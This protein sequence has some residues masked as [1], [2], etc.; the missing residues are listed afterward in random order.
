MNE[1]KLT[2]KQRDRLLSDIVNLREVKLPEA[3]E[4]LAA[5]AAN[6]DLS[7][8][9]DFD[10]AKEEIKN[11]HKDIENKE[12]LLNRSSLL[13]DEE[14]FS[15]EIR[16]GNRVKILVDGKVYEKTLTVSSGVDFLDNISPNSILGRELIGRDLMDKFM[17]KDTKGI[18]HQ[19]TILDVI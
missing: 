17:Y 15:P 7:E 2:K 11:I 6:G 13:A 9:S 18:E 1:I 19:V 16:T 10:S 4:R 5:A 14:Y 12:D 8:N 3:K